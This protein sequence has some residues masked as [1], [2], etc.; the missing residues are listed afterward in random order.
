MSSVAVGTNL[1]LTMFRGGVADS[2]INGSL[3]KPS[4]AATFETFSFTPGD[5]YS[6]GDFITME[7]EFT[8]I[9]I[10]NQADVAD[11]ELLYKCARGNV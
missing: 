3:I 2:T 8:S 11:L 6:P 10:G 5:T 9:G 7:V 4:L 1:K